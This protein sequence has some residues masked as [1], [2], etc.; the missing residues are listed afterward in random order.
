MKKKKN[1]KIMSGVLAL[2]LSTGI[3]LAN[4]SFAYAEV[5]PNQTFVGE[6]IEQEETKYNEYIV[7]KGDTLSG[8]S[9][10]ICEYYGKEPSSK[11]WPALAFLNNTSDLIFVGQTIIYPTSFEELDNLLLELNKTDWKPEIV[12]YNDVYGPKSR[13][14]K[15]ATVKDV[16]REIY[17]NMVNVDS[18]FVKLYLDAQLLTGVYNENSRITDNDMLFRLTEWIPTLEDLEEHREK[19]R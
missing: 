4:P 13:S 2:T 6:P 15:E 5:T 16:V 10:K 19:T 1:L 12:I 8:I 18:D 14:K 9:R 3:S 11:Y 17:G 7:E